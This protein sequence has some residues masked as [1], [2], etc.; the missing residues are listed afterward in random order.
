[1]QNV[2]NYYDAVYHARR[3]TFPVLCA[4]ALFD[5]AVIP[6]GQFAINNAQWAQAETYVLPA[7]HFSYP[8]DSEIQSELDGRILEYF[9]GVR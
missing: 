8:G 9:S 6:P 7:G 3:I 2:L 1:M 5:P 4:P